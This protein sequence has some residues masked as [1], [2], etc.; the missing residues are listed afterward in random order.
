MI[1][2]ILTGDITGFTYIK[3]VQRSTLI[4]ELRTL[5]TSW[6]D[7][8]AH[9]EV[10]R[11]DS[12]QLLLKD[13]P[14]ILK[15]SLQMR[16]WLKSKSTKQKSILDAKIAIGIGEIAYF[17][18][19]ILDADGEA[20]HL[21]GRTLDTMKSSGLRIMT[22][23]KELNEQLE[24]ITMLMDAIMANWT[25]GQ[26]QALFMV[27]ENKTQVQI[28]EELKIAQSAVNNRLKLAQWKEIDKTINYLSALIPKA[29]L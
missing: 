4:S 6:V 16:C 28:A 9:A 3:S 27:L 18:Q 2:Y 26:A 23:K 13:F 7:N 29:A 11:G 17:N 5:I 12:F 19:R 8:P 21:S 25:S 20:F 10:F 15:R 24:I 14:D 22:S 1:S